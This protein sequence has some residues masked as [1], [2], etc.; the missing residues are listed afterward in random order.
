M[1]AT[2][3]LPA[4]LDR[5]DR[6]LDASLGRLFALLRIQS[7]S[8]D[9]AYAAHCRAAAEHVAADLRSLGLEARV[10]PTAGPHPA[11]GDCIFFAPPLIDRRP[12][13]FGA[14]LAVSILFAL[15]GAYNP[16]PPAYEQKLDTSIAS[17]VENP[18]AGNAT[19]WLQ[20]Y[21]PE[22][23]LTAWMK[24]RFVSPSPVV[25]GAYLALFY[26]DKGDY[27]NAGKMVR[28]L[29]P[30]VRRSLRQQAWLRPR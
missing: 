17:V 9:P 20:E 2:V 21:A 8:T 27:L 30:E 22:A 12:R 7:V 28:E 23:R 15:I 4:V 29:P 16:W 11:N 5:I 24:E 18:V 14:A 3:V 10:R 6:D 25:A 26:L 19:A 1:K 13:L